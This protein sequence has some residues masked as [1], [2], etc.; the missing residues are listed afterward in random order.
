M[1]LLLC[2]NT[3]QIATWIFEHN[4]VRTRGIAPGIRKRLSSRARVFS[5]HV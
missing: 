3:E 1:I 5:Q 4:K 2:Y